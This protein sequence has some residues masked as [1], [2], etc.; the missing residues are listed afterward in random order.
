MGQMRE[1]CETEGTTLSTTVPYHQRRMGS[2]VCDRRTHQQ[3]A[4]MLYDFGLPKF[5]WAE[6]YNTTTNVHN[7]AP[8]RALGDAPR[9]GPAMVRSPMS[10]VCVNLVRRVPSL[11]C[12]RGL[13]SRMTGYSGGGGHRVWHPKRRVVV[14]SR[15]FV[16]FEAGL[17]S[18]TVRELA[19]ARRQRRSTCCT[20]TPRVGC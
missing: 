4:R 3:N 19:T 10:L 16:F 5:L 11:S 1:I 18:P 7:R 2:R 12:R 13:R 6:A 17:L 9:I 14:E 15:N 8:A 20:A